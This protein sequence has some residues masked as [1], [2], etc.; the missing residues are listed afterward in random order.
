M[1]YQTY[2]AR[3]PPKVSVTVH[4]RHPVTARRSRNGAVCYCTPFA[5]YG[6]RLTMHCQWG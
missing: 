6:A 4:S 3:K 5:A 1:F 2:T